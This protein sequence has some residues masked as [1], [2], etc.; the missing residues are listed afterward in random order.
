MVYS[1][2][3]KAGF[4]FVTPIQ[5]YQKKIMKKKWFVNKNL[6]THTC[7]SNSNTL[8]NRMKAQSKNKKN[9]VP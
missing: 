6:V 9:S 7:Y 1:I 3:L 2:I 8:K 5:I 4:F